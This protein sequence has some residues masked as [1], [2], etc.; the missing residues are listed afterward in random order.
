MYNGSTLLAPPGGRTLQYLKGNSFM[1]LLH[2]KK[3]AVGLALGMGL[4]QYAQAQST[5]DATVTVQGTLVAP[6][7][8]L[9]MVETGGTPVNNG[10]ALNVDFGK[11]VVSTSAAGVAVGSPLGSAKT[12]TFSALNS[13]R[14]AP[15]AAI[16]AASGAAVTYNVLL[17]LTTAQIVNLTTSSGAQTYRANDLTT[18]ATNAVLALSRGA[19]INTLSPLALTAKATGALTGTFAGASGGVALGSTPG[20]I[21]LTAQLAARAAAVPVPGDFRATIPLF[22]VYQ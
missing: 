16:T 19:T 21:Q 9:Q 13:A 17:D 22:L 18:G 3:T 20:T 10:G 11:T 1:R 14:T 2:F 6:T 8:A 5:P 15:C 12:V 4:V 7:C